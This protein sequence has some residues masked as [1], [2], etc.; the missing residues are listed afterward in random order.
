MSRKQQ[1]KKQKLSSKPLPTTVP[2]PHELEYSL[3]GPGI[4]ECAVVH[5]GNGE[6]MIV[7]SCLNPVT[8]EPVALEYLGELGVAVD[9]N[10]R[11]VVAT[12]FHD[13]H[14]GGL[15]KVVN[16]ASAAQFVAP[17]ALRTEEF[18]SLACQGDESVK[19][20]DG[21]SGIAEFVEVLEILAHRRQ[22]RKGY[23]IGPD[24]WAS[25]NTSVYRRGGPYPVT[26]R[27]L[28]PSAQAQTD[29]VG[30][31]AQSLTALPTNVR[32]RRW[33]PN[34]ISLAM[35][36]ETA[37]FHLLLGADLEVT[38]S[39]LHGWRAVLQP[40]VRPAMKSSLFKVAHH[41]SKNGDYPPVWTDL[42]HDQVH[43]LVTPFSSSGLPSVT[44]RQR[45]RRRTAS[46][47]CTTLPYFAK[48]PR[49]VVDKFAN[50]QA[51]RR[52]IPRTRGQIRLRVSLSGTLAS[53][54]IEL[55]PGARSL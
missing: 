22:I 37:K 35:Y 51:S 2:K 31:I 54:R 14:I 33:E 28:S 3:F 10:V 1:K 30:R 34:D 41:G 49:R 15:A 20:V 45:I 27:A 29:C 46:S 23:G 53:A 26:I 12:H 4:G 24:I 40:H 9:K 21:T 55:A 8:K 19:L 47:F 42:L 32:F 50:R 18:I 36:V 13:D 5:L 7:D 52:A 39:D 6:W 48:P 16:A 43:A 11:L 17:S 25:E 38:P 44:D